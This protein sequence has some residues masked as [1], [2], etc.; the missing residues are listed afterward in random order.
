MILWPWSEF[1]RRNCI[2]VNKRRTD[3]HGYDICTNKLVP[4][5]SFS[6]HSNTKRRKFRTTQSKTK[7]EPGKGIKFSSRTWMNLKTTNWLSGVVNRTQKIYKITCR[8]QNNQRFN[9]YRIIRK[10]FRMRKMTK[11]FSWNLIFLTRKFQNLIII[12]NNL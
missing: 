1:S 9:L 8:L 7:N 6:T 2:F 12:Q 11:I 4:L 5:S 10:S 3:F